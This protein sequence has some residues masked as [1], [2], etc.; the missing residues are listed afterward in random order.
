[1]DL[2]KLISIFAGKISIGILNRFSSGATALPGLVSALLKTSTLTGKIE[3]DLGLFEVDEATLPLSIPQVLPNIIIIN[4]LF[5][6]QLDRY[7]EIDTIRKKWE[8]SLKL[9]DRA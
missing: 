2:K 6:D 7:G 4:N 8:V 3:P 1:M 5:R 9:I